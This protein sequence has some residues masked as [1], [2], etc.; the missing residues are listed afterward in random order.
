M[1]ALATCRVN[2]QTRQNLDQPDKGNGFLADELSYNAHILAIENA[3]AWVVRDTDKRLYWV[4]VFLLD[5]I[6]PIV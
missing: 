5:Q 1:S 2:R 4:N 6:E 3:K